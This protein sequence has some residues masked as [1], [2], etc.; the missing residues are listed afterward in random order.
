VKRRA[1]SLDTA[2]DTLRLAPFAATDVLRRI[3]GDALG[4]LGFGPDE[5]PYRVAASGPH[6]RL[7]DYNDH[8]AGP[9]L[10]IIAA[11]IKRPYIWDLTPPVSAIGRCLRE[12]LHVYLLE[13]LPASGHNGDLGLDEY[14]GA[15]AACVANVSAE[16]AGLKPFLTGHS[17]GGTLAAIYSALASQSI[18]G[19][20]LLS[21]PVC[22]QPATS[23]FRDTLVSLVPQALSDSDPFP[24]SLLSYMS[25]LAAPGTFIWSRLTDALV[26][27]ADRG[28]LEIHNRVERWA[29]DEVALPGKLVHQIIDRLYREDQFCRGV[30]KVNDMLVGPLKLSV[31][32]I[33]VVNQADAVAPLTSIKPF[34][35][36]MP[37]NKGRIIEYPGEAGVSMQHLGVL[38]GRQAH[39]TVWPEIVSWIRSH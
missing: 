9:D 30:L 23:E 14:A 26:S 11:P 12:R 28:A 36:V 17:L 21:T 33:A 25:V 37:P 10:L 32:A 18:R 13:W 15:I 7:R 16:H 29:L 34:I 8:D 27:L 3:Q 35:E 4:A 1:V 20:V 6:W 39:A 31:P 2:L 19:L 22:F 5:H 24:G 38:I